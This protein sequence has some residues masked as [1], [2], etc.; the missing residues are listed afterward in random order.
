MADK[1][2]EAVEFATEADEA[3]WR[4]IQAEHCS[5]GEVRAAIAAGANVNGTNSDGESLFQAAVTTCGLEVLQLLLDAGADINHE[6][7]D[8]YSALAESIYELNPEEIAFLLKRGAD[9]NPILERHESLLDDAEFDLWYRSTEL[10]SETDQL[11]YSALAQIVDLL[12]SA[13]AK[14][15]HDMIAHRPRKWLRVFA[16]N[17]TGLTTRDGMLECER[18]PNASETFCREFRAWKDSHFDTWPDRSFDAMP[19]DFDRAAHNAEGQRL[20]EEIKR[21]VGDA[22]EVE[23]AY[24]CAE[25]EK[26]RI[27]NVL[28]RPILPTGLAR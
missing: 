12:K 23:Y 28:A 6:D 14:A 22:I 18:L 16:A 13:G 11:A 19:A 9:P 7:P 4:L 20:A 10:T 8:G 1:E 26:K 25:W 15:M 24:L 27:R 2:S 17:P 21:M 3:L 5:G